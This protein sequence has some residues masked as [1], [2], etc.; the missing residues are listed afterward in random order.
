MAN[1]GIE[2]FASGVE[3]FQAEQLR[4]YGFSNG[5]DGLQGDFMVLFHGYARCPGKRVECDP[6]ADNVCLPIA[7]KIIF[8]VKTERGT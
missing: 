6:G 4:V 7:G 5:F 2:G 1:P 3:L 8:R